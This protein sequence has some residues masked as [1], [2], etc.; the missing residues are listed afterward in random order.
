[1]RKKIMS[2]LMM[3]TLLLET[4]LTVNA[5]HYYGADN[6][7]V[8]FDGSEMI[9]NF[10]DAQMTETVSAIQPG[11]DVL[12]QVHLKN[13]YNVSTDWYMTNEVISTLEESVN[14]AEGGA[15]TYLLKYIDVNGQESVLYDS[16]VVG[17]EEDTTLEG[18][19]L[20]QATNALEEYYYLDRLE[21][22]QE[23]QVTLFVA[24]EGE[25]QGN[26]YQ[27]TLAQLKMN[28]AVELVKTPT[29][30]PPGD[31]PKEEPP[32]YT[33]IV[34]TGDESQIVLFSVIALVSGI[35]LLFTALDMIK[36]RGKEK[37]E[38]Q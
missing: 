27:D 28:F 19:G 1:M 11:D 5:E 31:P 26:D 8:Y 12:F 37:G 35:V 2:L 4:T 34:E 32:V 16:E 22:G 15:Y 18:E 33:T 38:L 29:F 30:N 6:W 14:V 20:H 13:R 17:G 3:L 21:A 25:T 36:K 10:T 9:S 7:D 23:A 24:L